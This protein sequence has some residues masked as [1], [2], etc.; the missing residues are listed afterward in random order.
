M[1]ETKLTE[2]SNLRWEGSRMMLPEHKEALN[3]RFRD[4]KKKERPSITEEEQ[5]QFSN[6]LLSSM[7]HKIDV[8][9]HLFGEFADREII[10]VV[11]KIDTNY[12]TIRLVHE[13]GYEWVKFDEIVKVDLLHEDFIG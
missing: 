13:D 9:V 4:L 6:R 2:G 10:A 12:R 7:R 11:D 1:K 5:E 8:T 3:E